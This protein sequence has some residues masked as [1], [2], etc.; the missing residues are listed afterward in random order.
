LGL[1]LVGDFGVE[2]ILLLFVE[3]WFVFE[4][5][6]ADGVGLHQLVLLVFFEFADLNF[7]G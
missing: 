4:H 1:L 5:L 7:I 3:W 2:L 6:F